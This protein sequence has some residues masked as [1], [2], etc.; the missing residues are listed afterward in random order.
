MQTFTS[1]NW[2]DPF[3]ASIT[4][5]IWDEEGTWEMVLCIMVSMLRPKSLAHLKSPDVSRH[6]LAFYG[7]FITVG[8]ISY[9]PVAAVVDEWIARQL[10]ATSEPWGW[11]LTQA[12][13]HCDTPVF[14]PTPIKHNSKPCDAISWKIETT[15]MYIYTR[16]V[17]LPS[18]PQEL[19]QQRRCVVRTDYRVLRIMT[20]TRLV[21]ASTSTSTSIC[22]SV[23]LWVREGTAI[24]TYVYKTQLDWDRKKSRQNLQYDKQN[25]IWIM[26]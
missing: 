14:G 3:S 23:H 8:F 26:C 2:V 19:L 4:S 18:L 5:R 21:C 15:Y 20:N 12:D 25:V 6:I 11:R 9:R 10:T 17:K 24:F 1:E 13:T 7:W 16:Q 22:T